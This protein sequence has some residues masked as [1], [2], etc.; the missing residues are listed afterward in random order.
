MHSTTV[1]IAAIILAIVT[2]VA[3][4]QEWIKKEVSSLDRII[5]QLKEHRQTL[6]NTIGKQEETKF[7]KSNSKGEGQSFD[8]FLL[9]LQWPGSICKHLSPCHVPSTATNNF[10]IHGLWPDR[11]NA[12]Y[13]ENCES[14]AGEFDPSIITP[15]ISKLRTLWTDYKPNSEP[16]F[17]AHEWNKHGTCASILPNFETQ[18]QY[19]EATMALLQKLQV[20]AALERHSI[21]P[22]ESEKYQVSALKE[23]LKKELGAEPSVTCGDKG[24]INELRFCVTKDLQLF[25]CKTKKNKNNNNGCESF[26][27]PPVVP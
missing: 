6:L 13:P 10:T 21:V 26:L 23:A 22:H 2:A 9:S 16:S 4:S 27:L 18:Q 15:F 1:L 24:H 11:D 5:L 8:Y 12:K 17:W 20:T 3:C 7:S 14:K 25:E 19:F